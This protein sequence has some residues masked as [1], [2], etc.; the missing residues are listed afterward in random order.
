MKTDLPQLLGI[1]I[2]FAHGAHDIATF[3]NRLQLHAGLSG[4]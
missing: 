4:Q 1:Q 3:I 2:M